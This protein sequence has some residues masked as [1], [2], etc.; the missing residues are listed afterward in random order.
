[1]DLNE[2]QREANRTDQRPGR[3]DEGSLL[4]PVIGLAS[5]TGSLVRHVKKRL[6]DQD[7]YELFSDEMVDELGD[8]LWYVANLSEKLGFQLDDIAERNLRKIRGR[9]PSDGGTLPLMLLDD[10]FPEDERL[11][12]RASV[13]FVEGVEDDKT[14]VRLYDAD[15]NQLGDR[16]SDNAYEDDGYRFH[17]AFH[18]TYAALLGWSPIARYFF[19]RRR[20]SKP[21]VRE[22]EDAGRAIAIEEAVSAFV[23]DYARDVRF[24]E[25]VK[26]V[27]FSLLTTIRRL[28]SGFE[29]RERT[30]HEWEQ[31][32]LRAYE[33]WRPLQAHRGGT[34]HLDLM[35]RTIEFEAPASV[36]VS[37]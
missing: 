12:R 37:E 21:K 3:D 31:A 17:D 1:M 19:K 36:T 15:G 23:F 32:I 28:V 6:R 4:F 30:A 10:D 35:A 8:V 33:V 18:L 26:H 25:G 14:M 5:E 22:V 2:F 34:L 20:K 9:W 13:R 11:P 7:A 29:V 16:L 27:D 24:L